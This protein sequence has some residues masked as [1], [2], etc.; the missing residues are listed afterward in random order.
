MTFFKSAEQ[1]SKVQ[2]YQV[3]M[4]FA[5]VVLVGSNAFVLSPILTEVGRGLETEPYRI[6][7]AIS[8]FGGATALSSFF[9]SPVIDRM[10]PRWTLGGA[11][12]LLALAQLLSSVS[13]SWVWLCLSQAGAGVAVGVLLPG[14]YATTAA[15]APPGRDA[16]RL[17]I[18]LTGW[19]LSLV[20][21]VPAAAF[22]AAH[23][24][25]RTVYILL[26]TM[27]ACVSCG[28]FFAM[29]GEEIEAGERSSPG[30]ALGLPGVA[31]LLLIIFA[32]M[33]AFYGTFAFFGEGVRQAFD[34]SAQGS[35]LFVL[36]YGLG[37]GSAGIGLGAV[38]PRISRRYLL[39]VLVA[40]AGVY[41]LWR[42]ALSMPPIAFVTAVA[43]GFLNQLGLNALV[44][45]LNRQAQSARGAVMGLNSGVT[46]SAVFIGPVLMGYVY[47]KSGFPAV[48]TFAAIIVAAAAAA[49]VLAEYVENSRSKAQGQKSEKS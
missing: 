28:L 15:T 38:S 13:Q 30:R 8:A 19:A 25:W 34:L 41:A 22:I 31:F 11:A 45:S 42:F 32:Y 44:V 29:R 21:A 40:I 37:F 27:S 20:L 16:A 17:G 23:A 49:T 6:A 48:V 26:A 33:T 10:P 12:G 2:F 43:W 18:V 36:A 47:T 39:S 7:W 35:G 4:L 9:L 46:Y 1:A 3:C 14:T 24:G 5:A